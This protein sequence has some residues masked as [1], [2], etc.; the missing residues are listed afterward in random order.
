MKKDFKSFQ[1]VVDNRL[2]AIETHLGT[3]EGRLGG[4]EG[5]LGGV[6]NR[7]ITVEN[8]L[9]SIQDN[10]SSSFSQVLERL[11][12]IEKSTLKKK[13]ETDL[14]AKKSVEEKN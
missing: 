10:I 13:N 8:S 3:V 12:S 2:E 6:E 14:E 1:G 4:V 5:R 11:E 9:L 7:L